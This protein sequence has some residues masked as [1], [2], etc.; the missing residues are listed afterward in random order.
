MN[1]TQAEILNKLRYR[2]FMSY[3]ELWAKQG[4]SARFAYHLKQLEAKGF[5][6]K[7]PKGYKL[8]TDGVKYAD[9]LSLPTAQP[10]TVVV[11]VPKKENKVLVMK[12]KKYPFKGY[13]EFCA[14]KIKKQET[15]FEA[16]QQ[17]MQEKMGITANLI[18]KGIEFLQTKEDGEMIMHHHLHIF[19]AEN[20]QGEPKSG[21]WVDIENFQPKKPLPHIEQTLKMALHS[22]FT[23]AVTD[24]QKEGEKFTSYTTSTWKQF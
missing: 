21:E 18:Y 23:I 15:I 10:L 2:S 8:T 12:R 9:Y 4:D 14:S 16:A 7:T 3:N 5:I 22:G 1:H 13:Q 11:I 24:M 19:L 6:A 20:V 17:R